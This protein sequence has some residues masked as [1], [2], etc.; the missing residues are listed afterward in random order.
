MGFYWWLSWVELSVE[1]SWVEC[2]SSRERW[3]M[4]DEDVQIC[5][6]N[7]DCTI[8]ARMILLYII[9]FRT[10][11]TIIICI[12]CTYR[13][14][15]VDFVL[16]KKKKWKEKAKSII[17]G[18]VQQVQYVPRRR[19]GYSATTSSTVRTDAEWSH[20]QSVLTFIYNVY[21]IYIVYIYI[22]IM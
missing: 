15:V 20:L 17:M 22:Y 13:T 8:N 4:S 5:F 3:E 10:L 16:V 12:M 19:L 7:L 6:F 11:H 14:Y 2:C 9:M 1:L 21:W 18:Y